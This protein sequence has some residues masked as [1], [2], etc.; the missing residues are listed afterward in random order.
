MGCGGRMTISFHFCPACW[1][2]YTITGTYSEQTA[3]GTFTE[4][5]W[6]RFMIKDHRSFT[7]KKASTHEIPFSWLEN[8][9]DI[10]VV[11]GALLI[12]LH[13]E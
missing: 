5:E 9:A 4:P 7:R 10:L 8:N 6:M 12:D 3:T 2:E 11:E 13:S 1:K